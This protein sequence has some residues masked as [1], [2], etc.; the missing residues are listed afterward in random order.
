MEGFVSTDSNHCTC[1]WH[2][3][4]WE[5]AEL[6]GECIITKTQE[7]FLQDLILNSGGE[8]GMYFEVKYI[9]FP[10]GE[11]FEG[12]GFWSCFCENNF[13]EKWLNNSVY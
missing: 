2:K 1:S 13:G 11:Q 4:F 12:A 7:L 6:N 9:L 10:K 8:I 5:T 3:D